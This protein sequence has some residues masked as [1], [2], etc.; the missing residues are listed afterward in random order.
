MFNDTSR[1]QI[2][3]KLRNNM[4]SPEL[5]LWSKLRGSQFFGLK[6][7]RQYGIDKFIVD[8]YCPKIRLAIEIDGNSHFNEESIKNDKIREN[9]IH[10][11]NIKLIR[12][13]NL[14]IRNNIEGVLEKIENVCNT[15]LNPS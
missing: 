12:F 11:F 3:Q 15:T 7:R 8:F 4:T 13:T 1:K 10:S 2:R 5:L 14:E 6:F 9:F